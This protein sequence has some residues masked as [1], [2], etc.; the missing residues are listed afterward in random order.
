M[1]RVWK[2]RETRARR[3][4]PTHNTA[5]TSAQTL[6]PRRPGTTAPC[7]T[8]PAVSRRFHSVYALLAHDLLSLTSKDVC[9]SFVYFVGAQSEMAPW[10]SSRNGYDSPRRDASEWLNLPER[11]RP[12]R[13]SQDSF[14]SSTEAS[15]CSH[16]EYQSLHQLRAILASL[17]AVDSAFLKY[18]F[19]KRTKLVY[20]RKNED[21]IYY[22]GRISISF[23]E[24]FPI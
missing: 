4:G 22:A 13:I 24:L 18:C 21:S 2:E 14:L 12:R 10:I 7:H 5:L 15:H 1:L 8:P 23:A 9:V 6:A 11:S 19:R 16:Y 17:L 20:S 3:D